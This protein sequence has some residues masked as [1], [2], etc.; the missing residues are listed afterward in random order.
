MLTTTTAC[1]AY[2]SWGGVSPLMLFNAP[3]HKTVKEDAK[4]IE[5]TLK[6]EAKQV[7]W[8]V[9][10][11]DCDREGVRSILDLPLAMHDTAPYFEHP[12]VVIAIHE[13]IKSYV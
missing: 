5:R 6:R 10:W 8:L 4:R 12:A 3:L 13:C 11:T 9:L 7:K 2:R 1:A